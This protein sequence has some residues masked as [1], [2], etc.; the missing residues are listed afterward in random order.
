M[1]D[2]DFRLPDNVKPSHYKLIFDV[3]IDKFEF[4]GTEEIDIEIV[5]P[6]KAITLHSVDLQIK[7]VELTEGKDMNRHLPSKVFKP[8]KMT[9]NKKA[10][11]ITFEFEH[12]LSGEVKLKLKFEGKLNDQLSGFYRSKYLD[13]EGKEKWLATTQFE[14]PYARWCFPCFDEPAFKATFDVAMLIDPDLKAV[15]N[16][17]IQHERRWANKKLIDFYT[18]PKMSTYLL[19]LGVGDFEF[20][21][22]KYGSVDVRMVTVKGKKEQGKFAVDLAKKFLKYF[23]DYSGLKYP[24]PK[25]DLIAVPDFA[26]GAMENWGAITFREVLVLFDPKLTST[27]I[28]K[29]IAEIIAHELWHQWS[30]NLVTMK[31]WNDL[32]LNESFATYMAFKAVDA[33]F[34]EWNVWEDFVRDETAVAFNDD[35]LKTTH[36]IE[37]EIRNTNDIEEVFDNISYAKGGNILRM[38]DHYLSFETFRKGVSKYLAKYQYINATSEDLWNSLAEVSDSPVKELMLDWIRK[39]GHPLVECVIEGHNLILKQ[40]KFMFDHSGH[41]T[42]MI[43]LVIKV[44]GSEKLITDILDDSQKVIKLDQK[45]DWVKI[46]LGRSGFYRIKYDEN[47]LNVLKSLV[48]SKKLD[49]VDRWGIESD[50]QRLSIHGQT[51][52]SKV[53]EFLKAYSNEDN[54]TVLSDIFGNLAHIYFVFSKESFWP[55]IWPKLKVQFKEPFQ[56]VLNRLGWEPKKG[57]SENDALLRNLAI[58]ALG[59]MED[60]NVVKIAKGKFSNFIEDKEDLP[61]DLK[62]PV[63]GIAAANGSKE[64]YDKILRFYEKTQN[65]EEKRMALRSLGQFKDANLLKRTLDFAVT[66]KVRLQE[67]PLIFVTMSA[68]PNLRTILLDWLKQNWQKVKEFEKSAKI[69]TNVLEAVIVT[70][71]GNAQLQAMEKFLKENPVEHK[72]TEMRALEKVRRNTFWLNNNSSSLANYFKS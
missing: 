16:M 69:F 42:W 26:A 67:V 58:Q 37:V 11:T 8:Y 19:Y 43:P 49:P 24:L 47:Q 53:L 66:D 25:L 71:V 23:E 50:L 21:E 10:E 56:K 57:E 5:K 65:L 60:D 29:R 27:M 17:P 64:T 46:N 70:H 51:D 34:S 32:W 61:A 59:F 62:S 12:Q 4:S 36:P 18:S 35:S 30:G 41:E 20:L 13:T 2:E 48:S 31:W 7:V 38:L 55:Q 33:Y 3:D 40:S 28:K 72:M 68:N 52:I 22:D 44:D 15:S 63:F 6:T 14:A 1:T 9:P 39:P 54:Y 45:P